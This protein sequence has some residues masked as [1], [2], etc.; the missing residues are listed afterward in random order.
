[1]YVNR[2]K[3]SKMKIYKQHKKVVN[4]VKMKEKIEIENF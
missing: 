3:E 2:K 1:M 4:I